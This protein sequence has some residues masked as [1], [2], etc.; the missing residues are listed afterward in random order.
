MYSVVGSPQLILPRYYDGPCLVLI[1]RHLVRKSS[2]DE[3]RVCRYLCGSSWPFS[4]NPDRRRAHFHPS[5]Q[6]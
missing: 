1:S 5:C 6:G 3:M 2:S 4:H